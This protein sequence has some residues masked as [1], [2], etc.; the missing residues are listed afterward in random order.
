MRKGLTLVLFVLLAGA[1]GAAAPHWVASWFAGQ[2]IVEPENMIPPD[3]LKDSTL[4]QVVR[5]SIGGSGLRLVLSN[6]FGT[7]PLHLYAVHIAK[8][9][10]PGEIDPATDRALTFSGRPDVIIPPGASYLSDPVTMPVAPFSD[11]AVTIRY[12]EPPAVETGHPGSRATSYVGAGDQVSAAKLAGA[13]TVDHWYQITSIE[14]MAAPR[15]RA[16]AAVGDSITDGRGSTTNG[17][18]RWTDILAERLAADPRMR[19]MAVLNAGFGGNRLL[20]D[21][22]GPSALARFDRD[23]LAPPGVTDVI[24]L[25]GINDVGT[26]T[27]NAPAT[28]EDHA[29]L[30]HRMIGAFEQIAAR[31][32][33]HRLK[34]YAGTIMPFMGTQFYHPDAAN[35]ADRTAVNAW[36]RGQKLFDGVIDF[37]LL[38]RDPLKPDHLNP[39]YDTGDMLHPGPAGY[40]AMGEAAAQ[41]LL[42]AARPVLRPHVRHRKTRH[43]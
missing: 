15:S 1:A 9:A 18:D 6:V 22:K 27:I 37:D 32:H 33:A 29:L 30:V 28:P 16:V 7:A 8:P 41:A 2:Q 5:L 17:N 39:S 10:G 11:M 13:L 23:V 14:V 40:R 42:P 4:R 19:G 24:V 3:V 26:L 43:H 38:M 36:I 31:A 34:A 25:E 35:E 20:N 12:G 21:G